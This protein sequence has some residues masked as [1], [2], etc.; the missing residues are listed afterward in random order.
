MLYAAGRLAGNGAPGR[1]KLVGSS[2]SRQIRFIPI[3]NG[4]AIAR[5]GTLVRCLSTVILVF[6]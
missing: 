1:V 3:G 4:R 6:R 2:L 5:T